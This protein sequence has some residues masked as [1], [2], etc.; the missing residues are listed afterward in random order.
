MSYAIPPSISRANIANENSNGQNV[1]IVVFDAWS[2]LNISLYGYNHPTTPNLERLAAK[3]IVYHNHF[4]GGHF[5]TPGTASLLTGT[6]AWTHRAFK[7]NEI[8]NASTE[9]NIFNVFNRY[10]RLA[11]THNPLAD[12]LLRQ[13]LLD[14]EEHT[15]WPDQY[16][17]KDPLNFTLFK[18]DQ[19]IASLGWRRGM[20]RLEA[21][22]AYTLF[23]SQIYEN[24]INNKVADIA[25]NFP[26]GIPNY[27]ELGL[28]Y[29]TLEQ[30][31]DWLSSSLSTAPQP[32]LGYYHFL[33]PHD[34]YNTR[35]D[36]MDTFVGE[37]YQLSNKPI[38]LLDQGIAEDRMI[39]R[40]RWY[41]EFILYVDA[42]FARLYH[43]LEQNGMLEN[44]WLILTSDHGEMFERGILGHVA[45]VF[46]QPISHLP[47]MIFPPDQKQRVDI[48][49]KTNAIDILPTALQI[50]EQGIPDWA[51]GIILPPFGSSTSRVDRDISTIQV[52]RRDS[53]GRIAEATAMLV[54]G[55][56]K[57]M[58]YF[59]YEQLEEDTE[60][61]EMYDLA[62]D[63]EELHNLFSIQKLVADEMLGTLRANI[64]ELNSVYRQ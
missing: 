28:N 59:G 54:R 45:P 37:N 61:V 19:D 50:T 48:F 14:I 16:F 34:P 17:Q 60:F 26:R 27:S 44:T 31:I 30:G 15:P 35:Q 56:Y 41:D 18:K 4:A 23:L 33:P 42:E 36:F 57:M 29:F 11:Y 64:D 20:K 32:F 22:H 9:N 58:W 13:F 49:D 1:L 12:T 55:D 3:A 2:A 38:H 8:V 39:D 24:F 52:E 10:H 40:H 43:Q 62:R 7:H 6:T 47:L 46:H 63:P 21:G 5:T 25:P 51:E 53:N